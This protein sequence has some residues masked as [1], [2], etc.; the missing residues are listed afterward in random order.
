MNINYHGSICNKDKTT[1]I[2][3]FQKI[4]IFE[5]RTVNNTFKVLFKVY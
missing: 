5:V 1:I 3:L 4:Y 2:C